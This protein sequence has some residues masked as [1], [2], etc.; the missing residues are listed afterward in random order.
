MHKSSKTE[1]SWDELRGITAENGATPQTLEALDCHISR[2]RF[3]GHTT[4]LAALT[5][6]GVGVETLLQN[7]FGR[8]LIPSAWAADA[9]LP[10]SFVVGE[11]RARF[12]RSGVLRC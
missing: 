5:G 1:I 7:V 9:G 2:R 3:L 6:F 12:E 11:R 10:L 8:G 4:A